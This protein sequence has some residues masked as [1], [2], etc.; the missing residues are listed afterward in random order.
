MNTQKKI[1]DLKKNQEFM[2][3]IIII[4]LTIISLKTIAYKHEPNYDHPGSL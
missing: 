4:I 2:V 3:I 1:F